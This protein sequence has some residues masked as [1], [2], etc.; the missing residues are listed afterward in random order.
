MEISD[1]RYFH[2]VALS[3]SFARAAERCHI[4]RSAVSKAVRRLEDELGTTLLERTTRT[5]V[6]T[7]A[8]RILQRHCE[9][10]FDGLEAMRREMEHVTDTATGQVRIGAMEVFLI[11]ALP[12]AIIQLMEQHPGVDVRMFAM[13][14]EQM[15]T[16][17]LD[18]RIDAGLVVGG[19]ESRGLRYQRLGTTRTTLVSSPGSAAKRVANQPLPLVSLE[20]F[21]AEAHPMAAPT[22]PGTRSGPVVDTLCA[23]TQLIVDG[24]FAGYLPELAIHCQLNHDE[25]VP[26]I[27]DGADHGLELEL[28]ALTTAGAPRLAT[29]TLLESLQSVIAEA[30]VR[31]CGRTIG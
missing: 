30:A 29:V 28:G 6:V 8:G 11:F 25:L 27:P 23:A 5:V 2:H 7:E 1:L 17:L 21:D 18:G 31:A 15:Q 3:R 12:T 26:A 10:L 9:D 16:E 20:Y 22:P 13:T 19:R 14:P 24:P 4:S